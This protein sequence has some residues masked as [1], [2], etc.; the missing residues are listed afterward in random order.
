MPSKKSVDRT[1][2]EAMGSN[3]LIEVSRRPKFSGK[4]RGF[5]VGVGAKWMLLRLIDEAGAFDGYAAFRIRDIVR[6][7]PDKTFAVR[8]APEL[9]HW[10]PA[11]PAG[12]FDLDSTRGLLES[13]ASSSQSGLIAIEKER[14]RYAQWIGVLDEIIGKYLYLLEVG[15]NGKW[16]RQPLGYKI[17]A[18]TSIS[19]GGLYRDALARYVNWSA[20]PTP[21][22]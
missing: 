22:E 11:P 21:P 14:E 17:C 13:F 1:L 4:N 20:K 6:V 15:P 10:P 8:A 3:K 9:P 2:R 16:D 5:V 7:R 12:K 18:I 19:M